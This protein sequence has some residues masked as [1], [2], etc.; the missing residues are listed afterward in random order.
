PDLHPALA[1][2]ATVAAS[3]LVLGQRVQ[4]NSRDG[5]PVGPDSL[6]LALITDAFPLL[7]RHSG[8]LPTPPPGSG[9]YQH[10]YARVEFRS[11]VP[12]RVR[13]RI[14]PVG[15]CAA[16]LTQGAAT[17]ECRCSASRRNRSSR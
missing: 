8:R 6:L 7:M 5:L 1:F 12:R 3:H 17:A 9:I 15:G 4:G 13:P 10:R 2:A 11:G 16:R 14:A